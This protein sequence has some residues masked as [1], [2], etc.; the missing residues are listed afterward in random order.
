MKKKINLLFFAPSDSIHAIKW[1][2]FF[3]NKNYDITWV[4]FSNKRI[5]EKR[6]KFLSIKKP[7]SLIDWIFTFFRLN[8][9]LKS[10]LFD[11]LHVHSIGSYGLLGHMFKIKKKI[12]T[13]WG[14]DYLIN[15]KNIFKNFVINQILKSNSLITTDAFHIKD[16]INQEF[17]ECRVELINFGIDIKK[18]TKKK[19]KKNNANVII[20]NRNFYEIY[21]IKIILNAIK[22]LINDKFNIKLLLIGDGPEKKS[23]NEFVHKN[24]LSKFIKFLGSFQNNK[25]PHLLSKANIYISASKSD[26]GLSSSTAEAMASGLT[27]VVS[28]VY[29]N[30]KWIINNKT[31]FTFKCDDLNSLITVLKSAILYNEKKSSKIQIN[32]RKKIIKYNN[33]ITEM[34]KME[35]L[36]KKE[37]FS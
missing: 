23:L 14:S 4:S 8:F 27:C 29:D 22:V 10:N 37:L 16:K 18:F 5:E 9:A 3:I 15:K 32:A 2:N 26:A 35:N 30:N 6:I 12:Y 36:L 24:N 33:Y 34:N 21:N 11:I 13:I 17:P 31:G 20:S 25:I 1:I 28:D 7:S 19:I